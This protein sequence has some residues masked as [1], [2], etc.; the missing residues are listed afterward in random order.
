M[1]TNDILKTLHNALVAKAQERIAVDGKAKVAAEIGNAIISYGKC[2]TEGLSDDGRL[3]DVE[4]TAIEA[5]FAAIV[6]V[7]VPYAKG[8]GVKIAWDGLSFFGIGW[9]GLKHYFNR[10]FGLGL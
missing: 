9:Q 1:N 3:S 4:R 10:W 8:T 6:D 2:W 5:K 7:H